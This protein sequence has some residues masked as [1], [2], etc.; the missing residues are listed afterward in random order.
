[1][2]DPEQALAKFAI[3]RQRYARSDV[4]F[5]TR[6]DEDPPCQPEDGAMIPWVALVVTLAIAPSHRA[7]TNPK[8]G[9]P[10]LTTDEQESGAIDRWL[11]RPTRIALT[12]EQRAR[13]DSVRSR[14]AVERKAVD[15]VAKTQGEMAAV[16]KMQ[17]LDA[18]YQKIVRA[19][20]TP[21]QQAVFDRN[22]QAGFTG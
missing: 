2:V 20:L 15:E 12:S 10:V 14:Y 7:S 18:R 6:P 16:L 17:Q 8:A 9:S 3:S 22:A 19:L 21:E 5:A 1:M 4:I 13:I 11:S